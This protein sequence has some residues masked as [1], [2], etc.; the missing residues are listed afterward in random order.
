MPG[1]EAFLLSQPLPADTLGATLPDLGLE[2][3]V[4]PQTATGLIFHLGRGLAPPYLQLR[5]LGRQV[6]RLGHS[7][8]ARLGLVGP[9]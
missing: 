5:V 8:R 2:L 1:A 4:R 7:L 3:E 6:S 9:A